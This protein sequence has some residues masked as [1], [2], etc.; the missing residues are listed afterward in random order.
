MIL[1][2]GATGHVGRRRL[3]GVGASRR[4]LALC[5][6]QLV[7]LNRSRV[8]TVRSPRTSLPLRAE[9]QRAFEISFFEQ[10]PGVRQIAQPARR[11]VN[12]TAPE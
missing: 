10:R 3:Q 9:N 2:T 7:R 5:L 12:G 11:S 6:L 8:A 4:S 1:V